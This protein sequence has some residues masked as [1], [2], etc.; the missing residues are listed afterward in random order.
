MVEDTRS[1]RYLLSRR[2]E[3]GTANPEVHFCGEKKRKRPDGGGE[4]RLRS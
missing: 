2:S 4:T 3:E 1:C